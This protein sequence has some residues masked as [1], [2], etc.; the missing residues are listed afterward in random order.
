MKAKDF[1]EMG[2]DELHAKARNLREELFR[3]KFK[4]GIRQLDNTGKLKVLRKDIA[5]IKTILNEKRA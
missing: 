4:N 1:R 5:R 3:L 2:S